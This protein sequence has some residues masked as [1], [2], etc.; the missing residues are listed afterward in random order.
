MKQ[1]ELGG[2]LL[3]TND[4]V[5]SVGSPYATG[6]F[7][8]WISNP[9]GATIKKVKVMLGRVVAG[10]S[11]GSVTVSLYKSDDPKTDGSHARSSSPN[12][13][14][15]AEFIRE[16]WDL[17]GSIDMTYADNNVL[18]PAEYKITNIAL[19]KP[20]FLIGLIKVAGDIQATNIF[21]WAEYEDN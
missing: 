15:P 2:K 9:T 8:Y 6:S 3:L 5:V 7:P 19:D 14:V 4:T 21:L 20:T 12:S 1:F 18:Y 11:G 10:V 17:I 16:N 13:G